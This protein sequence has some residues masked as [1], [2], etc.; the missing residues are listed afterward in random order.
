M[1]GIDIGPPPVSEWK[2]FKELRL[3]ALKEEPQAFGVSYDK[4]LAYPD[5][6]WRQR[7]SGVAEG[8]S[9]VLWAR[10]DGKPVGLIMGGRTSEDRSSHRAHI[11]GLY[12]DRS[13]R[14]R[15]VAK[16]LMGRVLA[17]FAANPGIQRVQVEANSDQRAAIELYLS[18]GFE[19]TETS[20]WKMGDGVEHEVT[21][22]EKRLR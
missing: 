1:G 2:A 8:E 17:G 22:L 10:M 7:L 13:A 20:R 4:E 14:R 21:S 19:E 18:L 5:E 15:G 11:W 3:S 16:G 6:K 12:V 9:Y